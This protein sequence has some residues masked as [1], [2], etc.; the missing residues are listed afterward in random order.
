[1][2]HTRKGNFTLELPHGEGPVRSA[3]P[4]VCVYH[5]SVPQIHVHNTVITPPTHARPP[6]PLKGGWGSFVVVT[7]IFFPHHVVP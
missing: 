3:V 1:M 4:L 7:M 5:V 2:A 6:R